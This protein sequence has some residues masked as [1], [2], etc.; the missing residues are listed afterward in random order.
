M[1]LFDNI[2]R[3]TT[4]KREAQQEAAAKPKEVKGG[5]FRKNVIPA[6]DPEVAL[7]VSAV[8]R[9]I[10][11]RAKTIGQMP[12]QLRRKD[13]LRNNFQPW[14]TGLGKRIN[15]L[16]QYEPNPLMSASSLWEQVTI[17]RLQQGN[18][19][20]YI[21]RDDFGDPMHL[22]LAIC[23]GYNIVT[24]KYNLL[25]LSENGIVSRVDVPREDVLHFPNTYRRQNGFWGIPTLQYAANTLSLIKTQ[26]AQALDNAAKGGRVKLLIGEEKPSGGAGT[27][28]YGMYG[29]KEGQDYA[30]ELQDAMYE[31]QDILALRGLT[32]VKNISMNSAE[33]ELLGH[34]NLG[35]DDVARFW[36]TPRPLLML[37]TNSH[38]ND[39]SSATME[40]LT[41]TIGPD[42]YDMQ[43]E[44]FRKLVGP[45]YLGQRDIHICEKPLMAMD[46]ER[47]A[48]VDQLL[49]QTGVKSVNELRAE[50]DMPSVANGD[51]IYVSTNLAELGSEKLSQNGGEKID[52]APVTE[53]EPEQKPSAVGGQERR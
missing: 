35:M 49:L 8:Y 45:R 22:W 42:R 31:G 53:P 32:D 12:V 52:V 16:L 27:L 48:K 39:Y 5:S 47:Q 17:N 11:L 25:Y 21:E 46:P 1:G 51:I 10:E 30:M 14:M 2:F 43:L 24:G 19:F 40:Y 7:T 20:V 28:A 13:E 38:Y 36:A 50:H 44:I 34:L 4:Q 26:K 33:M 23:S 3:G 15:Y 9:A 29:K 6:R 37:D 41:R 18:G